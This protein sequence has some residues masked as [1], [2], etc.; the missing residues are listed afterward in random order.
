VAT[1]LVTVDTTLR[2]DRPARMALPQTFDCKKKACWNCHL[3][4]C[5]SCLPNPSPRHVSGPQHADTPCD[6][7]ACL[8]AII[9]SH[10][11]G[12]RSQQASRPP[13]AAPHDTLSA[14]WALPTHLYVPQTHSSLV[15]LRQWRLEHPIAHLPNG[16]T[17]GVAWT[18]R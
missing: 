16:Q 14:F 3:E 5:R 6:F 7:Q 4:R 8:R 15:E 1:T 12:C 10:R 11:S 18:H 2:I 13:S 17:R 9:A